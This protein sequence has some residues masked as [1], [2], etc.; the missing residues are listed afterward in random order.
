ME[1]EDIK[2]DRQI[3]IDLKQRFKIS[4]YSIAKT[5]GT[6]P[7]SVNNWTSGKHEISKSYQRLLR[8]NYSKYILQLKN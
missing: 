4:Y 8:E 3:V 5:L 7:Q 6:S 1:L 2:I